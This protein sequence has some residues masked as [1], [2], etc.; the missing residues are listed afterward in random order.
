MLEMFTFEMNQLLESLEE[1]VLRGESG[2]S[3]ENINEI[4]RVMHTIKG[5]AAM[6]MFPNI[7]TAAHGIEDLFFYLRERN[8][9]DMDYSRITDLVLES[10]DF[11]KGEI[12]KIESGAPSDG[13]SAE[14]VSRIRAYL[15]S[16]KE[17][18]AA[19]E[20]EAAVEAP[21]GADGDTFAA[22]IIYED[23]TEMLNVRAFAAAHNLRQ[24]GM[25]VSHEPSDLIDEAASDYIA[26]NG[27][28]LIITTDQGVGA[29]R[30]M[31]SETIYMKEFTLEPA[32]TPAPKTS[33]EDP[34]AAA[35]EPSEKAAAHPAARPAR[36]AGQQSVI[37]V[38]VSKLD[39]LLKLMGEL[40]ISEAMVTQ[41]PELEN[42]ELDS[43]HKETRQL[44]KIIKDIQDAVMSMRMV[45][46][47]T[48][49]FKMHRIVRDMCK[50]LG[51]DIRLD[52][53]GDET[54][55]DKNIIEHISD[56]LMHIIRNSIDHGIET[57]DARVLGGKPETG[58]V[59]LE[60]RNSGSDVLITVRD[61]G[62]GL[63]RAKILKKARSAG[64]LTK[65]DEDY[66]DREAFQFIFMPGFST[67]DQVTEFS[68]RGVGM[69][70]VSKNLE[71]VGGSVLV[72]SAAGEGSTF[73]LKIPLTL[74]IIEG[75]MIKMGGGK[76]IL[77]IISIKDSFKP[78][79]G[80]VFRDPSGNEMITVRGEV[81]NIVRL[82]EFFGLPTRVTEVEDGIMIMVENGD[83]TVCAFADELVGE[84][85]V[86]VKSLP[87]YIKKPRG[88][89]GCTLLGNGDISLIID[90]AGFFG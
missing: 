77:P 16:L 84:Q 21:R 88:I 90:V 31:L 2:Y 60:A 1:N 68:G 51:K 57:P 37:S 23:G 75:M 53:I 9:P 28:R 67:N 34:K 59:Q 52:V 7:S 56:P 13:D 46:L 20:P 8:A 71:K 45:P 55:V 69:D 87:K 5:S 11:I 12:A 48:T 15:Q 27:L 25:T 83:E 61:D 32:E 66:A 82:Y 39:E 62:A 38:N 44:R 49:F 70:V 30:D 63:D 3:M 79:R 80:D 58:V 47:A 89:S 54:E 72:E 73:T 26:E 42:L 85:Q 35:P 50:Q 22:R 40:V 76:Y 41:N 19:P 24:R 86:V 14:Y 33:A 64:L 43:F 29:L 4:F 74:A 81:Y 10:M 6:M 36:P 18:A 17:R 78:R 65:P